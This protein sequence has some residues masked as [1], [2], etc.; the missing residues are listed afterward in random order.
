MGFDG[1]P[2]AVAIGRGMA[3][4]SGVS[5][6]GLAAGAIAGWPASRRFWL[7]MAAHA[8]DAG[9]QTT[10][11]GPLPSGQPSASSC[12][13]A[14]DAFV[15]TRTNEHLP[16]TRL[17]DEESLKRLARSVRRSDFSDET[18]MSTV[19]QPFG[20]SPGKAPLSLP[21]LVTEQAAIIVRPASTTAVRR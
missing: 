2:S 14:P 21:P 8:L 10:G 18:A 5:M 1:Q 3:M 12:M 6:N 15:S 9:D 16:S 13:A 19:V 17:S 7:R 20:A 4:T 11:R